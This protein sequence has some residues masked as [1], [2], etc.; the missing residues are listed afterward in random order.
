VSTKVLVI[1]QSRNSSLTS[2]HAFSGKHNCLA[3]TDT[4]SRGPYRLARTILTLLDQTLTANRPSNRDAGTQSPPTLFPQ[5]GSSTNGTGTPSRSI[6]T[7]RQSS[8]TSIGTQ[9]DKAEAEPPKPTLSELST[10]PTTKVEELKSQTL[11]IRPKDPPA[12]QTPVNIPPLTRTYV[13]PPETTPLRILAVDDN[14]VNL[15]LIRRYLQ[16]RKDD[17]IVDAT[18]GLEAVT[19]VKEAE[20][21]FD[22]VFMD[23]SMPVMD[24]F[25]ATRNIRVWENRSFEDDAE[26]GIE[27]KEGNTVKRKRNH[28][29][30]V[31][32]TGLGSQRDRDEA[33][34]SGFDDF[35]TKPVKLLMVG[36]LLK[37]LSEE[38][39]AREVVGLGLDAGVDA[40]V[41]V[42]KTGANMG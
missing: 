20:E 7:S 37:K 23:I 14:A 9:L 28:A 21:P 30:V 32:M 17:I 27:S 38:K 42:P 26:E 22:V 18:N 36:R 24:G 35:M 16:K 8:D 40:G 39:A 5:D 31:A 1:C 29:Y 34:R 12:E 11:P 3:S 19:A 4:K 10:H 33:D 15:H 25:E 13:G 6:K 2:S 41:D